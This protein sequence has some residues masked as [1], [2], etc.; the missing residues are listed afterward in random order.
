M[1]DVNLTAIGK[2]RGIG[3]SIYRAP[4]G[5]AL[6]TDA[7]TELAPAFI[8]Q[9]H[10]SDEGVARE[11]SR[12]FSSLKVWGGAEAANP[13]TEETIRLNFELV[14]IANEE[15]L[16]SAYG[17]DA[18]TANGGLITIDYKG[19]L[20]GA[21]VWVVDTEWNGLLRRYVF[22][23]CDNVTDAF[24]TSLTD[25]ELVGLPFSLAVK[26]DSNGTYFKEYAEAASDDS[27]SSSSA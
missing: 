11:I 20:P 23:N 17:D 6:P 2:P 14:E 8:P 22:P 19:A 12:S 9:G 18:V 27:S 10:V 3:G 5:T 21:S 24:N 26:P 13:K 16:K 1:A 7:A 15:A 25:E 4:L